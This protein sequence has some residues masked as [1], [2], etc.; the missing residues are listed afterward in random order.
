MRVKRKKYSK[1]YLQYD[2]I[3]AI[4]N[5]QVVPQCVKCFPI[6]TLFSSSFFELLTPQRPGFRSPLNQRFITQKLLKLSL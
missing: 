6:L 3:D 2:F 5:G 4:V 1:D